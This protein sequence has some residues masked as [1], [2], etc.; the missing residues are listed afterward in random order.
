MNCHLTLSFDNALW[1]KVPD[2][3][4]EISKRRKRMHSLTIRRYIYI[5]SIQI[6]GL[7][8]VWWY[9]L[10]QLHFKY[11]CVLFELCH[12][13]ISKTTMSDEQ[14]AGIHMNH[15]HLNNEHLHRWCSHDNDIMMCIACTMKNMLNLEFFFFWKFL[16]FCVCTSLFS[17]PLTS[18]VLFHINTCVVNTPTKRDT[19]SKMSLKQNEFH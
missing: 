16:I 17:S 3:R 19:N 5:N 1:L 18:F 7:T 12:F 4:S 15:M 14:W 10:S 9:K 13:G 2:C 6:K 8:I 11:V